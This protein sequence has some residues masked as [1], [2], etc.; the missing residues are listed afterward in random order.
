MANF[1]DEQRMGYK[2]NGGD[3]GVV[4]N[5]ADR[6]EANAKAKAKADKEEIDKIATGAARLLVIE[7][8]S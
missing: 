3:P 8:I 5:L 6:R 1:K 7:R 4:A 2:T